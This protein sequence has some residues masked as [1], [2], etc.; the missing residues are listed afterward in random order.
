MKLASGIWLPDHETYLIWELAAKGPVYQREKQLAC[1]SLARDRGRTG[2]A[3]DVGAHIGLWSV[4]MADHFER[5]VAFEP[6]QEHCDCFAKNVIKPNVTLYRRAVGDRECHVQIVAKNGWSLKTY[7]SPT[8]VKSL[9]RRPRKQTPEFARCI[10]LD[11]LYLAPDFIK[12]D[13]EGYEY[14]VVA[15]ALQTIL[16]YKPIIMI[17]QKMHGPRYGVSEMAAVELLQSLGAKIEFE[18]NRDFCLAWP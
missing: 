17:E 16:R 12:I 7:T 6:V 4:L 15:G 18:L 1:Y 9:P 3:L 13:C 8:V 11:S 2:L 5:V 14:K 10:A